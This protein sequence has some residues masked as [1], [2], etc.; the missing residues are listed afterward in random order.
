MNK[1]RLTTANILIETLFNVN[2]QPLDT[3]KAIEDFC[4][5]YYISE[6]QYCFNYESLSL[7]CSNLSPNYIYHYVDT[8]MVN[9]FIFSMDNI[10]YIL[11]PYISILVTEKDMNIIIEQNNLLDVKKQKL[12]KYYNS[13]PLLSGIESKNLL[14]AFW[15]AVYPNESIKPIKEY[16]AN[17]LQT[18]KSDE[19]RPISQSKITIEERYLIEQ[20]FFENIKNGNVR[21][22]IMNLHKMEESVANLKRIGTTIENE[23]VGAA[24]NRTTVRLAAMHAGL[25][26]V[27]IDQLANTALLEV[28]S[29]KN[30]EDIHTAKEKMIIS[31]C[32]A[33][34]RMKAEK[35]SVL[36][37]STLYYLENKYSTDIS[38]DDLCIELNI[39][40]NYLIS[41][42]K[43]E[44]GTTP[45]A[46]LTKVRLDQAAFLLTTKNIPISD[47]SEEV[48]ISD[49]NYFVKLFKKEFGV[50]PTYYRH[51]HNN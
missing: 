32:K 1:D 40:K 5:K 51:H 34:Q 39:S 27:I 10:P 31:I 45:N 28:I 14:S 36:I 37:Q 30:V 18:R 21:A 44:V 17:K 25:P 33:I 24:I 50:T 47:I 20:R 48:G 13:L 41:T 16:K 23:R 12:L 49:P 38:L 29:L 42:F 43:K 9:F 46:Y 3:P 19:E 7:I 22:S 26:P 11:S 8:L 6:V 15:S 2:I 35:Y 4:N